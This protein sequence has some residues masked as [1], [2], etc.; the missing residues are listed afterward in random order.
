[1]TWD[2]LLTTDEWKGLS[3]RLWD[4]WEMNLLDLRNKPSLVGKERAAAKMEIIEDI[5]KLPVINTR[6]SAEVKNGYYEYLTK[7]DFDRKK[8]HIKEYVTNG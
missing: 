7:E 3:Q 4:L 1:M 6:V 8:L 5:L 2:E